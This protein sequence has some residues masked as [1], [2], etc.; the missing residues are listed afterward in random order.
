[1]T[2]SRR[3]R[4]FLQQEFD[5]QVDKLLGAS[6]KPRCVSFNLTLVHLLTLKRFENQAVV[7][8]LRLQRP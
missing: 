4:K 6:Q 3:L 7:S 8:M 5:A 2:F 1:M